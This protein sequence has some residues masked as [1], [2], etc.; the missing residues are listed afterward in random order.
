VTLPR[1]ETSAVDSGGESIY[2]ETTG[3]PDGP[4]IVLTHGAGGSHA[5]WYQQV[6]VLAD[7]GYRVVTWDCRGF[8]RSTFRTGTHGTAAAVADIAAVMDA[9]GIGTAHHVG[10]SMGGWWVASFA[11]AHPERVHACALTNTVAGLW[12]DALKLH[13]RT[14]ATEFTGEEPLLGVHP[15]IGTKFTETEP[16]RA[17]LYQQLNTFHTPPMDHV[18]PAL[19]RTELS[20]ADLDATGIPILVVTGTDDGLFPAKLVTESAAQLQ[21]ATVVE[22]PDVGHSAYFEQPD[23][24]NAAVLDFFAR[25]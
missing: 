4:A 8:G 2:Y 24:F 22:L 6:P 11:L 1:W 25:H 19:W 21:N 15:A 7:A 14:W 9:C 10:Q 12:T 17:F 20:H 16:A 18:V 13:F 3:E 5:V 23:A